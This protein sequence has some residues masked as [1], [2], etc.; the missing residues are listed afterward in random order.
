MERHQRESEHLMAKFSDGVTM[1]ANSD[2]SNARG[3]IVKLVG[4]DLV[5]L[6][7]SS[8]D[9][10]TGV[11]LNDPAQGQ[12]ALLQTEGIAEV[13]ADGSVGSGGP[14]S[15]N[16]LVGHD[17]TGRIVKQLANAVNVTGHAADPCAAAGVFI[18]VVVR[19]GR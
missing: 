10:P 11:L 14:I 15:I 8:S 16:G 2:L 13:L 18:R 9:R 4:Q 3:K 7:T 12:A 5:D 6:V 1:K 17:A 19:W